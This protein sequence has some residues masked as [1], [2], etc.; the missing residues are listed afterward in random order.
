MKIL[1]KKTYDALIKKIVTLSNFRDYQSKKIE[2]L[3]EENAELKKKLLYAQ[4]YHSTFKSKVES[5]IFPN[6]DERG[7]GEEEKPVIFPDDIF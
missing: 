5:V 7:L 4:V 6:T 2:E 3:M 1:R